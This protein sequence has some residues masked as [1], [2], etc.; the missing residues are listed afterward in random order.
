MVLANNRLDPK[1]KLLIEDYQTGFKMG[2]NILESVA[3][4]YKVIHYSIRKTSNG[5]LLK[6]DFEKAYEM[7]EWNCLLEISHLRGFGDR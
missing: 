1:L 5:Y 7:V 4:A 6:L 2:R 3:T